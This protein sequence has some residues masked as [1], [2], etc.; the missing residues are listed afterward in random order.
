M[1][2]RNDYTKMPL[3]IRKQIGNT[4]FTINTKTA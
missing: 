2:T 1:F 4:M 3:T